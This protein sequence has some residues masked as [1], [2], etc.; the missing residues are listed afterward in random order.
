MLIPEKTKFKKH[1]KRRLKNLNRVT[2][3]FYLLRYGTIGLQALENGLVTPQQIESTRRVLIRHLR[4]VGKIWIRIFPNWIITRKPHGVRMGRGK[5]NPENHVF[6]VH[7][8][9][10]LIEIRSSLRVGLAEILRSAAIKLPLKTRVLR[11]F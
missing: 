5:G 3:S 2:S 10:V 1:Q 7:K 8:G 11:C 6:K 4:K 9:N